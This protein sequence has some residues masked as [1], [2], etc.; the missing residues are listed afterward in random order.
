MEITLELEI[1]LRE[2]IDQRLQF[3]GVK[4]NTSKIRPPFKANELYSFLQWWVFS[5]G[6][7]CYLDYNSRLSFLSDL[8]GYLPNTFKVAMKGGF[9]GPLTD[10][11]REIV[12]WLDNRVNELYDADPVHW[13]GFYDACNRQVALTMAFK[14]LKGDV[15]WDERTKQMHDAYVAKLEAQQEEIRL[16]RLEQYKY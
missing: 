15:Q 13:Q 9:R 3:H 6:F 2:L 11:D 10:R 4:L 12:E 5:R 16:K 7:E 8:T 14:F 1:K